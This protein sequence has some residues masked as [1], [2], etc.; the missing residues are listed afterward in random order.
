MFRADVCRVCAWYLANLVFNVGMK[1]SHALLP[2]VM[3]LTTLQIA[4][5]AAAFA[6]ALAVG[7]VS[8][9]PGWWSLRRPLAASTALILSGTLATNVSLTLLS[10]SFTH[11][12]S[13]Q[14]SH[15]Y[16]DGS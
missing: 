6:A 2:D 7:A 8:L 4:A 16:H 12:V 13:Q 1:R 3:L 9:E 11:V 10:V 15:H 14:P 5:G